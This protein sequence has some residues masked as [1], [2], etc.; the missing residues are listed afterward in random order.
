NCYEILLFPRYFMGF[1][2]HVHFL[3]FRKKTDSWYPWTGKMSFKLGKTGK[4]RGHVSYGHG[5]IYKY[6][7]G[8]APVINVMYSPY[9]KFQCK[10]KL[11]IQ[12]IM[13]K[14]FF[15]SN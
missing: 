8:L 14:A 11:P 12:T 5:C 7:T 4:L 13:A 6:Q 15:F 1:F 2:L 9:Y 3:S 10:E